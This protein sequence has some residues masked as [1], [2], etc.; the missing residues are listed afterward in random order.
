[1]KKLLLG[2]LLPTSLLSI[3]AVNVSADVT[4]N[5]DGTSTVNGENSATVPINGTIGDSNTDSNG[6]L[7]END[8]AW[9]NVTVPTTTT[10]GARSGS[11][12]SALLSPTYTVKNNSGRGV[13]VSYDNITGSTTTAGLNL[14][15]SPIAGSNAQVVATPLELVKDDVL[16]TNK[17]NLANLGGVTTSG[18]TDSGSFTYTYTGSVTNAVVSATSVSYNMTLSFR[19]LDKGQSITTPTN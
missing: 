18:G 14:N 13:A 17:K 11:A 16:Q 2:L 4:D 9:I 3:A 1:M 12:G 5:G 19:V 10:F 6:G 7:P 15:L 8:I